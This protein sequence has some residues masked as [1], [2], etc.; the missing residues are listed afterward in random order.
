MYIKLT[1][2]TRFSFPYLLGNVSFILNIDHVFPKFYFAVIVFKMNLNENLLKFL[3]IAQ[4]KAYEWKW[5]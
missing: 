1:I 4:E 3:R 2:L 5:G